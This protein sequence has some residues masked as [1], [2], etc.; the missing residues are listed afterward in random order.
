[1]FASITNSKSYYYETHQFGQP[2]NIISEFI[3]T[4]DSPE[5]VAH[6]QFYAVSFNSTQL[7]NLSL[8]CTK[9]SDP[10]KL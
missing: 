7:K 3:L 5:N 2:T 1:M 6:S 9:N 4:L 8:T 10:L